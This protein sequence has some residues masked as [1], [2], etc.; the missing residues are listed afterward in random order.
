M[1][2]PIQRNAERRIIKEGLF[3]YVGLINGVSY[4]I[5]FKQTLHFKS[6]NH[7]PICTWCACH[8]NNHWI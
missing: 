8:K 3:V 2:F 7:D 5:K 6:F 4:I 1:L